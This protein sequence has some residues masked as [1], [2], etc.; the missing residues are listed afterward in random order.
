[1]SL[2]LARTSWQRVRSC[3]K[4]PCCACGM[5]S[6]KQDGEAWMLLANA[7]RSAEPAD[8]V[9]GI[10][11][12]L[13][14]K[15]RIPQVQLK[16]YHQ[17]LTA[18]ER[19]DYDEE[20]QEWERPVPLDMW[21]TRHRG[22]SHRLAIVHLAFRTDLLPLSDRDWLFRELGD[23]FP[24]D[25]EIR[26]AVSLGGLV[27][28]EDPRTVFW[29]GLKIGVDWKRNQR[30]WQLIS[31]LVR[32]ARL[33]AD[34]LESDIY[35]HN[36]VS[37]ATLPTAVFRLK[38]LLPTTLA[39]LIVP[40]VRPRTQRLLLESSRIRIFRARSRRESELG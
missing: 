9:G 38:M 30:A 4:L 32:R 2:W 34:L 23:E 26:H 39:E 6:H 24:I 3:V 19:R 31:G 5:D 16:I 13:L 28:V 35:P 17:V 40:G 29:D 7:L 8:A 36:A 15:L 25:W 20:A 1:M 27:I 33:N 12:D 10:L 37:D 11:Q 18:D 22:I 14:L 21:L